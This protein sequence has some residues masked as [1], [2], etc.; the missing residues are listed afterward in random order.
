M[1]PS[2]DLSAVSPPPG[3]SIEELEALH[4]PTRKIIL[5][6]LAAWALALVLTL[7]VPSWHTGERSWWPWACVCGLALGAIGYA[8]VA[9]GRGNAATAE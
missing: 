2:P 6:G 4:V 9:R 8:Y 5:A 1:D 3:E 7:L